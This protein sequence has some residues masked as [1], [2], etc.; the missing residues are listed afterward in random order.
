M[1]GGNGYTGPSG[2][3]ERSESMTK[4][5]RQFP[6]LALSARV[7]AIPEA[8]S[9]YMNNLIYR[10]RRSGQRVTTLSLGEAYFDLP[11]FGFEEEDLKSGYHYS[12]SMGIPQLRNVIARYYHDSYGAPVDPEDEVLISAG[13]KPLIFMALQAI[14][15]PGDE[16]LIHEP[17]W[18]SYPEQIRLAGG[19][20]VFIPYDV[21]PSDFG[22][23]VTNRTKA[24]IINNPNN[25][26]GVAYSRDELRGIYGLMRSRGAFTIVDEAYSDFAP[27]GE[28]V[29]MASIVPDKDGVIVVNSLS[30][31]LGI[32]GW[33]VGY[34]I[35]SPEAVY[36]ILKLNQHLIT[37]AP[38]I[39]LNYLARNFDSL[40]AATLPQARAEVGLRQRMLEYVESKGLRT[41]GG[42]TTFYMFIDISDYGRPSLDL[43]MHLLMKYRIGV[44]P[45]SAY[46][47][48]TDG[49][50]RI[51]VGAE[52]EE[53]IRRAVDVIK[54]VVDGR[55]YDGKLISRE[56]HA[57]GAAAFKGA[58]R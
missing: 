55:E 37:C 38:T 56:L 48:S 22:G 40:L 34:V 14:L 47:E 36:A 45:G 30:K 58:G 24:I 27:D 2:I 52:D 16:V 10:L 43:A 13:S 20:P 12:E 1:S 3:E 50:I 42:T 11:F 26:A 46:G 53:S 31:N 8:L 15:E 54:S 28:F 41:L 51:G 17:A 7:E 29:S 4:T 39:L 25:P 49:F 33:R 6:E 21:D 19:T 9:V 57:I 44:V 5:T 23:Y 35:S 18:L 32:S